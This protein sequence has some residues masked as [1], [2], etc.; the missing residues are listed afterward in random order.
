MNIDPKL[1]ERILR[2]LR[3]IV[4]ETQHRFDE[5]KGNANEFEKGGY[6]DQLK[7]AIALLI[8]LEQGV[9][10]F[11]G[12]KE[13]V[14]VSYTKKECMDVGLKLGMSLDES[15]EFYHQY[16]SQGWVKGNGLPITDLESAMFLWK[17]RQTT[18]T[19]E[20]VTNVQ[21]KTPRQL[22]IEQRGI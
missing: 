20:P 1:R 4:P 13:T 7:E 2:T 16:N 19:P 6:S 3:W 14:P 21:G 12:Q 10:F 5:Q 15:M 11:D 18:E 9:M 8:E 17:K 22:D